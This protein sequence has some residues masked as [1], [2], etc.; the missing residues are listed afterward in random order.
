MADLSDVLNQLAA[1]VA[2]IVYPNGIGQPSV[3]SI[4]TK[5]YPGWPVA[6]ELEADL[7]AGKVHVSVYPR[8]PDRKSTRH[9]GR[10]WVP[11]IAPMHTVTLTVVGAVVT[12]SGTVSAQNLL[13]NLNGISYIYTMLLTDTLT[14]AATG[15]ASL[16]PGASS[17]G[18][19]V[20]LTGAH[21]VFARV[22][23]IGTSIKETKRQ[24]QQF[25]I[26]VWAPTP[27]TR[28]A[29][30][31]QIDSILSDA[32]NMA[33]PDGSAGII[34]YAQTLQTDQLEKAGL[35][36]RDLIYSVDYATTQ[37]QQFAEAIAL[38]LNIVNAQTGLPASTSNP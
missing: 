18:P 29:T 23:G 7:K 34:R 1:R 25:Q 26:T 4:P 16:I 3:S 21:S 35:Y 20:T 15:L 33:L 38:A 27:S 31:K 11:I 2:T 9:L 19:V 37:T 13:I 30:A 10:S 6:N 12:L 36:R 32:T 24:E 8:G 22:G 5:I 17:S 28:D 14:T